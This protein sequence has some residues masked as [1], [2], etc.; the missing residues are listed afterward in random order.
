MLAYAGWDAGASLTAAGDIFSYSTSHWTNVDGNPYYAVEW[1][2]D[3]TNAKQG[4]AGWPQVTA[5]GDFYTTTL[6]N[7]SFGFAEDNS[8]LTE[9]NVDSYLQFDVS[10]NRVFTMLLG[11]T[12]GGIHFLTGWGYETS[13]ADITGVY[14][15]DSFDGGAPA[16]QF[17]PLNC[18]SG[19]CYLNVYTSFY[20]ISMESLAFNAG[21]VPPQ[22]VPTDG[23]Q[24][25]E[26]ATLL[27]LG[28][29]L[30]GLVG[31]FKKGR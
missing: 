2:F 18:T 19:D 29:G 10:N 1:W 17:S 25:P 14:F 15:T 4:V 12:L 22:N 20:L 30:S 3:G 8:G 31:R 26:P 13:G 6:F 28:T 5:G 7:S 27:L 23:G 24:V 16:L 21:N 9:A 11:N